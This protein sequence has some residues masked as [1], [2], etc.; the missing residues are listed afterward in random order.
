MFLAAIIS[1]SDDSFVRVWEL[2]KDS[3]NKMGILITYIHTGGP[4][5]PCVINYVISLYK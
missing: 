3:S 5:L 4:I 2:P 1:Y